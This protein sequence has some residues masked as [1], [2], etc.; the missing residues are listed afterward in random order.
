[1]ST[2][3]IILVSPEGEPQT[4]TVDHGNESDDGTFARLIHAGW[5]VHPD[6]A[7]HRIDVRS[8]HPD[9]ADRTQAVIVR[10]GDLPQY[11]EDMR[12]A[13]GTTPSILTGDRAAFERG[14][15][16]TTA[17]LRE[18]HTRFLSNDLA[19]QAETFV[20]GAA[21]PVV[22]LM[23]AQGGPMNRERL[24]R[25]YQLQEANPGLA[26]AGAAVP[27]VAS[28]FLPGGG[29]VGGVGRSVARTLAARGA[30]RLGTAVGRSTTEGVV[31][32]AAAEALAMALERDPR[33]VGS[34]LM[35]AGGF[36]AL[37]MLPFGLGSAAL[38][39]ARNI[40]AGGMYRPTLTADEAARAGVIM[41]RGE[42]GVDY[43]V[44]R[45]AGNPPLNETQR[46]IMAGRRVAV[47]DIPTNR[48]GEAIAERYRDAPFFNR[49][50]GRLFSGIR[51]RTE[52]HIM[53]RRFLGRLGSP[54][55]TEDFVNFM[56]Q[57]ETFRALNMS[58]DEM[59]QL[60]RQISDEMTN[61][62]DLWSQAR[63]DFEG[64]TPNVRRPDMTPEQV[65]AAQDGVVS[66]L[67][68]LQSQLRTYLDS[69]RF[70]GA[71]GVLGDYNNALSGII[72]RWR[73][74][75]DGTRMV[76]WTTADDVLENLAGMRRNISEFIDRAQVS[77]PEQFQILV[78]LKSHLGNFIDHNPLDEAIRRQNR[79]RT[80]QNTNILGD[81][82]AADFRR[83]NDL[84]ARGKRS[85]QTLDRA[86]GIE[87]TTGGRA[88]GSV[89]GVPDSQLRKVYD[90]NKIRK[91]FDASPDMAT[92]ARTAD[93]AIRQSLRELREVMQEMAEIRPGVFTDEFTEGVG[94]LGSDDFL[95][96]VNSFSD[97]V[98]R[99]RRFNDIVQASRKESSHFL[100]SLGLAQAA[101][102]FVGAL[103]GGPI[104]FITGG[105]ATAA[106][107][108]WRSVG[109]NPAT[110]LRQ[111]HEL[112]RSFAASGR[113]RA[114]AVN[115]FRKSI[116]SRIRVPRGEFGA[117]SARAGALAAYQ[118]FDK[119]KTRAERI[120]EY[121]NVR[122]S[123]LSYYRNPESLVDPL[124]SGT[125]AISAISPQAADEMIQ[126]AMRGIGYLT[127]HLNMP[128]SDPLFTDTAAYQPSM[129]EMDDFLRRY[130]AINYPYGI[131]EDLADGTLTVE[132][133][134]AVRH[135]WPRVMSDIVTI[136]AEELE[137]IGQEGR[138][139]LPYQYRVRLSM[140][141]G[142]PAATTMESSFIE[143]M[144]NRYA[145]TPQQAQAQ[146]MSRV[147]ARQ[148]NISSGYLTESQA[149]SEG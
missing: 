2:R 54:E 69:T 25:I 108:A 128:D 143:I 32:G 82:V 123:L 102:G 132:A 131:L 43:V 45:A 91:L 93:E 18:D 136:V 10:A 24:E 7:E 72:D 104:G 47:D 23:R 137:D 134:D 87:P 92:G 135:T 122:A 88:A 73:V 130:E 21:S 97:V 115:A 55:E 40:P 59:R 11:I 14:A 71:R 19:S 147:P 65:A 56:R 53:S 140:L 49:V 17:S 103:F 98:A 37:A 60:A 144:Q 9:Y 124:G 28:A 99:R 109:A 70:A 117:A 79:F 20:T 39:R 85:L 148:I 64:V 116:R 94:A 139:A 26:A 46:A 110:F 76:S 12:A 138:D 89:A 5:T 22:A 106:V 62:G 41:R 50:M 35:S 81:E 95:D 120:Q 66:D 4:V 8:P 6:H 84:Y 119:E 118:I 38:A 31:S 86:F 113:P 83:A 90:P 145:Q 133:A 57:D 15:A 101:G 68:Q 74:R 63:R 77:S 111:M 3:D 149:L 48:E 125:V 30:G 107:G 44:P 1:M 34:R 13:S 52:R 142:L 114:Q 58:E 96:T 129:A 42:D 51:D 80:V 112:E 61:T 36:T 105:S 126:G 121:Q 78:N 146:G 33:D 141:T 67:Q 27:E 75:D 16:E 29:F 127:R 100:A